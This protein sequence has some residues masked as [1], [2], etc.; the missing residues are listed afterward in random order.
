MEQGANR[1][2][3][4]SHASLYSEHREPNRRG[5]FS[6]RKPWASHHDHATLLRSPGPLESMLKTTTETGDIGLFSIKPSIPPATYHHAPRSRPRFGDANLL[7]ASRTQ[8]QQDRYYN[9]TRTRNL[10]H[11]DT[12]SDILSLYGG[13]DYQPSWSTSLSPPNDNARR[14]YSMTTCSS[15]RIPSPRSFATSHHQPSVRVGQRPRS[16]FPYPTRLRRP[17]FR[18]SSPALTDHGSV[19]QARALETDGESQVVFFSLIFFRFILM[20][21]RE[22]SMGLAGPCTVTH[23]ANCLLFLFT[24]RRAGLPHP[25]WQK[26]HQAHTDSTR[27]LKK[28]GHQHR[29]IL[30]HL[31][32]GVVR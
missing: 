15:R 24:Q 3:S 32:R 14:S 23:P 11:R 5:T 13:S 28:R 8:V 7:Q 26:R 2:R 22:L 9:E 27:P 30:G 25:F 31:N 12:T 19:D 10:S 20:S 16:P 18:P 21:S 4:A 6:N 17:G 29:L 1:K